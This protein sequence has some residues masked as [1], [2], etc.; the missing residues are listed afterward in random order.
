MGMLEQ[1]DK[2]L[3]ALLRVALGWLFFYAGFTKVINPAWSAKGYLLGAKSFSGFY[4]WLASDGVLPIVD[5]MNQWGL[6]L[7]GI[8]LIL[9]IAVRLSSVLGAFMMLMYWFPVLDFP[10]VD[11]GYLVDDHIVYALV[12]LYFAAVGA[13]RHYGL[14]ERCARL[15][16]CMRSP[17]LR[18]WLN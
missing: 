8:S 6:T 7:L 12:L 15:P 18:A 16:F 17:K 4:A 10:R 11:H 9:G 13:G 2:R 1:S 14:G 5:F 3:L